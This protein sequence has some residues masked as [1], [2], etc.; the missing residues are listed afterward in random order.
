MKRAAAIFLTVTAVFSA[1]LLP[2]AAGADSLVRA[3]AASGNCGVCDVVATAVTIG[4]W[5]VAG[6]AG[7]ALVVIV[8]AAIG[9]I[10]S[11]G[12]AEKI[13]AAKKQVMGSVFGVGIVFAAFYLVLW[14][15]LA[16]ANPSTQF[17]YTEDKTEGA[18]VTATAGLKGFLG[19][20]AW[21]D[22]CNEADLRANG[23]QAGSV[24]NQTADCK[25]WGDG[26]PCKT[27]R[28]SICFSGLCV[29]AGSD[30]VRQKVA[31]LGGWELPTAAAAC[32]Y[33]AAVDRVF[34]NYACSQESACNPEKVESGFCPAPAVCCEPTTFIPR[35]RVAVPAVG[36][37]APPGVPEAPVCSAPKSNQEQAA[38][39]RIKAI[40][41][42][43]INNGGF[44]GWWCG[45]A[46]Y[47]DYRVT[48]GRSCTNVGGLQTRVFGYL[49]A[50][51]NECGSFTITGGS[52]LGHATNGEHPVGL[53]VDMAPS[54]TTYSNF[55]SCLKTFTFPSSQ[56]SIKRICT[57]ASYAPYNCST[58]ETE[59]HIHV[60]FN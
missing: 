46:E 37:P 3:C 7:L 38:R 27:D 33:L 24:K 26:T 60:S 8:W 51:K 40:G 49:E 52:E 44:D 34:E 48:C 28:K 42:I 9:M 25:F 5:L 35:V 55:L 45:G 16:F 57:T 36:V 4:K 13:G 54:T 12:N 11:G 17:G 21:W 22:I 18:K 53:G 43:N 15:V 32:D 6:A 39:D 30:A 50:I 59:N 19:G 20:V 29:P 23:D 1:A 14:V 56:V 31:A 41:G 58:V 2:D 10:T 47:Q